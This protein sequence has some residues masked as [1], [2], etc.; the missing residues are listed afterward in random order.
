M[1]REE[2]IVSYSIKNGDNRIDNLTASANM[3]TI[4]LIT[5]DKYY[6]IA[7]KIFCQSG[8]MRVIDDYA[9]DGGKEL[10]TKIHCILRSNSYRIVQDS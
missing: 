10:F 9:K 6:E 5:R 4:R 2:Y 3:Y 1:I 7:T 8:G